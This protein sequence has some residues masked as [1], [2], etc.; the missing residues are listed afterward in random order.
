MLTAELQAGDGGTAALTAVA[1][2]EMKPLSDFLAQSGPRGLAH[3]FHQSSLVDLTEAW[4][5]DLLVDKESSGAAKLKQLLRVLLNSIPRNRR[6]YTDAEREARKK[7]RRASDQRNFRK[8][9]PQKKE[10]P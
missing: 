2:G 4:W 3:V 10:R 8:N 1:R 9:H 7:A 6:Q 5:F